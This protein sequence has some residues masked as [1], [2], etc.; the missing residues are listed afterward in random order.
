MHSQF[1][2]RARSIDQNTTA[3]IDSERREIT[4]KQPVVSNQINHGKSG[5]AHSTGTI[6]STEN[7]ALEPKTLRKNSPGSPRSCWATVGRPVVVDGGLTGNLSTVAE[8]RSTG[9]VRRRFQS[10]RL[11]FGVGWESNREFLSSVCPWLV[12]WSSRSRRRWPD[13]KLEHRCGKSVHRDSSETVQKKLLQ[14]STV[15]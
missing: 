1:V 3:A 4:H 13:G 8:N 7:G 9:T 2:A 15:A 12:Q 14:S 6:G 10:D 5:P 11:V